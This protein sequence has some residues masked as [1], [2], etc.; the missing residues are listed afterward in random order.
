LRTFIAITFDDKTKDVIFEYGERFK[1]YTKAG[2]FTHKENIHLTVKFIGEV[3]EEAIPVIKKVMDAAVESADPFTLEFTD[4][5]TFKTGPEH[6]LWLGMKES[7]PLLKIRKKLDRGLIEAGIQGDD[8]PL[9]PHITLGRRVK[10]Q[11]DLEE[12]K[13][14]I[15]PNLKPYLVKSL[16]L[17]ESVRI[18]GKL[19][20]IPVAQS[21]F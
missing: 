15:K 2:S 17:M 1:S 11:T 5:G 12:I 14:V 6:I 9:K 19:T 7:E 21:A 8:K 10:L 20:Y 18:Q 13:K 4:F 16:T 3:G